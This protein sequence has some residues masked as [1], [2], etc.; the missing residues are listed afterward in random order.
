MEQEEIK[1]AQIPISLPDL[2]KFF[3][4]PLMNIL[5]RLISEYREPN[6]IV[7]GKHTYLADVSTPH[8]IV[9]ISDLHIGTPGDMEKS[10]IESTFQ[11]IT[12][13]LKGQDFP[14]IL[15]IG[16]DFINLPIYPVD[17]HS[18][19]REFRTLLTELDK[20]SALGIPI[21]A[22]EG[23]HDTGH[24]DWRKYFRPLLQNV[25]VTI[26]DP[27]E[28]QQF[29]ELNIIGLPDYSTN[30]NQNWYNNYLPYLRP[31]LNSSGCPTIYLTHHP[32]AINY[33]RYLN[34]DVFKLV[35]T[36][37]SHHSGFNLN[38]RRLSKFLG[39]MALRAA[40]VGDEHLVRCDYV[41]EAHHLYGLNSPGIARHPLHLKRFIDP[42]IHAIEIQ[43]YS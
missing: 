9:F 23:N 43:P 7:V 33:I 36:G 24:P 2:L 13:T 34:S 37:H 38:G 26:L 19:F 6:R 16:G 42:M 40:G 21:L 25:G 5:G 11:L 15:L 3:G 29:E 12:E 14:K 39:R 35:L 28:N 22:V 1:P 27:C 8:H 18:S 31:T 41:D 20:I 4:S 32:S 17:N 30:V 10:K